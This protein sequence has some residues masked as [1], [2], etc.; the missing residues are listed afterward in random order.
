MATWNFY[1]FTSGNSTTTGVGS[2]IAL[3][4]SS[5]ISFGGGTRPSFGTNININEWNTAMHWVK[6]SAEATTDYCNNSH[7]WPITPVS[8]IVGALG[9]GA[10][11]ATACLLNGT[12]IKMIGGSP[13]HAR[14][15]ITRFTHGTQVRCNPVQIWAGST[16]A[17][18]NR[19]IG[20]YVAL[21]DLTSSKPTWTT[22]GAVPSSKMSLRPHGTAEGTHNW[23]VGIGL[24][25]LAVG[26]QG[27]N[28]IRVQTTY[29]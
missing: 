17:G 2:S 28:V 7:M 27:S 20:C 10:G 16:V 9:A 18:V 15:L 4:S 21:C 26:Y 23:S 19:P 29:Y 1:A 24:I 12:Y 13:H 8:G 25:P 11:R 3:S 14:G 22:A 6:T 5:A